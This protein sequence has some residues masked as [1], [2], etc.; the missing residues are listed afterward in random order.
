MVLRPTLK[1]IGVALTVK[2]AACGTGI[3]QPPV[4][5][6]P[7]S[8]LVEVDYPPPP[9][10]VEMVPKQPSDDAVWVMGEWLWQGRRWSWRAGMWVVSPKNAVYARRVLV[11]R[12]DGK[13]FYAPG[14]WRDTHGAAMA[15]PPEKIARPS[16]GAV[17][18]PEG[19][20]EP[21]G[22]NILPDAGADADAHAIEDDF[23]A[24]PAR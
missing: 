10:R 7:T 9:A 11:R 23:D 1:A 19:E 15:A 14:S 22:A 21:T 16:S 8:E 3:P 24:T 18:N 13:L 4:T 5:S 6:Q 20:T 12:G 2:F 17:V